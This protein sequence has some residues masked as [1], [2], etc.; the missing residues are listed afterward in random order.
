MISFPNWRGRGRGGKLS[1]LYY[2][3]RNGFCVQREKL[4]RIWNTFYGLVAVS[5]LQAK[6]QQMQRRL[7]YWHGIFTFSDPEDA[8]I[9]QRY[10]PE[11]MGCHIYSCHEKM[12]W[13]KRHVRR[14]PHRLCFKSVARSKHSPRHAARR[15]H[16]PNRSG[17]RR[18]KR[19]HSRI[20]TICL[21]LLKFEQVRGGR[22]PRGPVLKIFPSLPC[23]DSK[24]LQSGSPAGCLKIAEL[25]FWALQ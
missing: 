21:P 20:Y 14:G 23:I 8:K 19:L 3:P 5:N 16:H 9:S 7:V 2:L 17:H 15:P 18:H 11:G 24:K 12:P 1:N 25:L 10:K 13:I 4:D 6:M 22:A